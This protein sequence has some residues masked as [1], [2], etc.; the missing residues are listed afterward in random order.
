QAR[1]RAEELSVKERHARAAAE[2]ASEQERQALAAAEAANQQ[3]RQASAEAQR[4]RD[5]ADERFT[6]AREAVDKYLNEVTKDPELRDRQD[7]NPLREKLLQTAVPFYEKLAQ[8][9]QGEADQEAARGEAHGRLAY[10]RWQ[11][12]DVEAQVDWE[13]MRAV[14]KRLADEF[15]TRPNFR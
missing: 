3:E 6:L 13:Q 15:T 11:L 10:L 4:A 5:Q 14:F 12:G 8:Q 7:L 2:A 1:T 9:R